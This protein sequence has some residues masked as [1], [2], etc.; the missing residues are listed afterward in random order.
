MNT[1]KIVASCILVTLTGLCVALAQDSAK[2]PPVALRADNILVPPAT[3]PVSG[4]TIVNLRNA[5]YTGKV[6]VTL[7]DGWKANQTQFDVTL[8]PN[9]K[10][11][12]EFSLEKAA[13]NKDHVYPY[14]ITAVGGGQTVTVNQ[15]LI[16]ATTP[17]VKPKIDGDL[18]E[19]FDDAVPVAFDCKGKK[20]VVRTYWN[21]RNFCLSLEV[22]EDKY[23][24]AADAVQ[25][26]LAYGKAS[27]GKSADDKTARYEFVIVG[28]KCYQLVKPGAP[29][30]DTLK[31]AALPT[32][33][34][35]KS[36]VAIKRAKDITTYEVSIPMRPM[37]KVLK[38][39]TGRKY[40]F[41]LI[42]HDPDGA[43]V[44]EMAKVTSPL[45]GSTNKYAWQKWIGAKFPE[46]PL[47]DSKLEWGFCTS[48]H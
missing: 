31:P 48:I 32:E 8:E 9:E 45:P 14:T 25:F 23:E 7:P 28:G 22:Q 3:G 46:K 27:T 30:G 47:L 2:T 38:P 39:T 18:A 33:P 43:G 26:A 42:V 16:C 34:V 17:Y 12:I 41:G 10:K 15:K 36:E 40:N 19:W 20:T 4:V 5:P 29:L 35:A 21:K 13:A 37:M 11:Q 44:R 24:P 1:R 6:T